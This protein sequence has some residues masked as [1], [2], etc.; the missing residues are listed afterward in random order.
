MIKKYGRIVA[1]GLAV[2][3]SF[4]SL[5]TLQTYAEATADTQRTEEQQDEK[6]TADDIVKD[7]SDASFDIKTS[8]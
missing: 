4:S 8:K 2:L 6:V 3:I 5:G 1:L 7:I